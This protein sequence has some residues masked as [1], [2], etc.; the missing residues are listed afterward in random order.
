MLSEEF[1]RGGRIFD[2]F[3]YIEALI[4]RKCLLPIGFRLVSQL[5]SRFLS[6]KEIGTQRDEAMRRMPITNAAHVF[7]DAKD[8]LQDDDAWTKPARRHREIS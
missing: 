6:P 7:I 4:K 5:N 1:H 3:P 2:S 8:F